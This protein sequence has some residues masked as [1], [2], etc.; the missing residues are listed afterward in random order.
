MGTGVSFG[1]DENVLDRGEGCTTLNRLDATALS[2]L[3]CLKWQSLCSVNFTTQS[4][5]GITTPSPQVAW[6][7]EEVQGSGPR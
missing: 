1:N 7:V 4:P 3:K 5:Q 2:T 6:R